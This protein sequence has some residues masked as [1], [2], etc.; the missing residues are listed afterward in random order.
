MRL[1]ITLCI[2]LLFASCATHNHH[3]Q[4]PTRAQRTVNGTI[5]G[6]GAGAIIG[7]QKGR[8]IEGSIIGSVI[9]A[10][11]GYATYDDRVQHEPVQ[12]RGHTHHVHTHRTSTTYY[13]DKCGHR[14]YVDKYGN[15]VHKRYRHTYNPVTGECYYE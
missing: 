8:G 11:F 14:I 1:I 5:I 10:I 13:I 6:A 15:T 7:H 4:H 12:Q 2:P 3:G 9:G